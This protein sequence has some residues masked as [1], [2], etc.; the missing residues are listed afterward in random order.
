MAK[1]KLD[2]EVRKAILK[3]RSLIEAVAKADGNETETRKHVNH[4][5]GTVMGYDIFKHITSEYAISSVGD[6]LHCDIAVK[7]EREETSAPALLVELKRV[8]IDLTSKHLRQAASYAIDIGGEWVLLTN[9]REWKLYHISF[10]KPPQTKLT[11]SWS[12]ISDDP[13]ILAEKFNLI[14]YKNIKKGGLDKLWEKSNVL[15][16]HNILKVILSEESIKLIRREIK[17]A[18]DVTVSPE[19]IVGAVRRMLNEVALAEM[20]TIKISLPLKKQKKST[21]YKRSKGKDE[22]IQAQEA[23]ISDENTEQI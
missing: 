21:S 2:K 5:F 1:E 9:G 3:A 6:T 10:G 15:T 18:T 8:N 14:G 7:I 12:L 22:K 19:E 16:A 17:R 4:I 13:A 11:D 23:E 20:E